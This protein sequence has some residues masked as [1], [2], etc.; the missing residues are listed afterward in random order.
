MF[1]LVTIMVVDHAK[2]VSMLNNKLQSMY[3]HFSYL[4][5]SEKSRFDT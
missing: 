4:G 1:F 5:G 3:V 2:V